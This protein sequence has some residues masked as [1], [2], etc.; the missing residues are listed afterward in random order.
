MISVDKV[1]FGLVALG[2]VR[3]AFVDKV[4]L[5]LAGLV[6]L[7]G[8]AGLVGLAGLAGL[9]GLASFAGLAADKAVCC[10]ADKTFALVGLG[11]ARWVFADKAV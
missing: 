1:V 6:G 5:S 2:V 8:L 4:V 11:V 10:P 7:A 9:V 3:L